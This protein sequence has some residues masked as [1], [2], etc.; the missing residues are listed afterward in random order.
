MTKKRISYAKLYMNDS[1]LIYQIRHSNKAKYLRLQINP[2]TGLEVVL[3]YGYKSEE[4]EKFVYKK[5]EWIL[6]HL[7]S[8]PAAEEFTYLG[9]K[10]RIKQRFDLFLKKHKTTLDKDTLMIESPSGA[11]E[12]INHIFNAWLK[13]R[14]KNY[15]TERAEYLAE[16]HG[17]SF[18]KLSLRNQKTRWGSCSA[19]GNISLN[20]RLMKYR[21]DIIDYVIVHELCHLKELNHSKKFWK[22]V[23][24]MVP[25]YKS[26]KRELK[27]HS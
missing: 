12:D 6:K 16:Q 9:D 27:S 21:K 13:H 7:K 4:A 3:P 8:V 5:R 15:L 10:I 19:S 25:D 14:A 23:E 20:Y 24:S 11:S 18:K 17:F 26:L 22:L 1:E 2:S